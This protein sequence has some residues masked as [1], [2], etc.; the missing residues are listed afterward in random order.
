MNS[1]SGFCGFLVFVH[2]ITLI[3]YNRIRIKKTLDLIELKREILSFED[4][5]L[6][7]GRFEGPLSSFEP[8]PERKLFPNLYNDADFLE[9]T[10]R[11]SKI[12]I[13]H[14]TV[15]GSSFIVGLCLYYLDKI[16]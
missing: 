13:Y 1:I 11:S 12:I 14:F 2:A 8:F 3:F 4:F 15:I 5:V 10:N 7:R 16:F 9:F 6:L